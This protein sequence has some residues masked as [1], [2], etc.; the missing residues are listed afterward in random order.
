MNILHHLLLLFCC[1]S[2]AFASVSDNVISGSFS[3]EEE[4]RKCNQASEQ[5]IN[6]CLQPILSYA[7]S[8]QKKTDAAHF[9]PLQGGDIFRKLCHLY[10]EFKS[11]TKSL[12]C[13]SLSLTAVDA[14]YSLFEEH[15]ACFAE[16]EN[17]PAYTACKHAASEAM[18]D[19]LKIKQE[20]VDLY[21]KKLCNVMDDYLSCCRPF[22]KHKCGSD[23]WQLV[24]Q[25]TL[26]SLGVTMPMCD[27]HHVLI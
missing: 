6:K 27:I 9:S 3:A 22:V 24:S 15:A 12:T 26:D 11:C 21:F 1:I 14:S 2:T 19:A 23:A 10:D 13:N 8:L 5:S 7:N 25:I 4:F 20:N 17:E 18:D 16:V